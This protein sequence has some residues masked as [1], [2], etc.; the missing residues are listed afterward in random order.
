MVR[1]VIDLVVKKIQDILTKLSIEFSLSFE[2]GNSDENGHGEDECRFNGE[3]I[4]LKN[5][6][7]RAYSS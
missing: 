7:V 3:G 1:I 2:T 6:L 4:F 5:S